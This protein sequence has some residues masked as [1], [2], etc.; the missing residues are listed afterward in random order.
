[1]HSLIG[2]GKG[3]KGRGRTSSSKGNSQGKGGKQKMDG[4]SSSSANPFATAHSDH[5]HVQDMYDMHRRHHD[6]Q[7]DKLY[8]ERIREALPETAKVLQ[9][10]TLVPSEWTASTR[11]PYEMNAS[12]G[13]AYV[14]KDLVPNVIKQVGTTYSPAAMV[15]S[16][17]AREL[18]IPYPSTEVRCTLQVAAPDGSKELIEVTKF[19]TQLGFGRPVE[20]QTSGPCLAAPRTMHKC[21][22]RFDTP[23]GL[24]N[25]ELTGRIVA[26]TV[27]KYIHPA[28]FVDVVARQ[29]LTATLMVQDASVHD[30]LRASGK[31]HVYFRLHSTDP[32][33][34]TLE[35]IWLAEGTLHE[36][37]LQL[38][39]QAKAMGLALK[40]NAGGARFGIRFE[41]VDAMDAYAAKHKLG[42]KHKF[43][44]FRA[45][46]V[47]TTVGLRG[48]HQ[49]F[50]PQGWGIEEIEY[51]GDT[52][53]V[54]L[55]SKRGQHDEMHFLDHHQRKVPVRIKALNSRA[56][57]MSKTQAQGSSASKAAP[58][59]PK[60]AA[61]DRADAQKALLKRP[62]KPEQGLSPAPK[63]AKGATE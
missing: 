38:S 14:P 12:G 48:V 50:G 9:A 47:P 33:S 28:M 62:E 61:S 51:F 29:D 34:D 3:G 7:A 23:T 16:Q 11:H 27:S 44:R 2:N 24:Q 41:T 59:T 43:G 6:Q 20:Q 25:G 13:I 31:D 45:T 4:S 19:L 60:P 8:K 40:R 26:E 39:D 15:T 18:G 35:I 5:A 36:D 49:M 58:A 55:A 52:G 63:Q 17:A 32:D 42:D 22:A 1:M 37:A 46:N 53:V 56:R 54:F 21:V 57:E 30:L 10:T